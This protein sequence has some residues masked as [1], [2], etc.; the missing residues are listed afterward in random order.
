MLVWHGASIG[1]V[2]KACD[3]VGAE[4][5]SSS[6]ETDAVLYPDRMLVLHGAFIG[7]GGK[8]NGINPFRS[9]LNKLFISL[10]QSAMEVAFAAIAVD[11]WMTRFPPRQQ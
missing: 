3:Q 9:T 8:A 1:T 2:R 6:V 5:Q 11:A 4:S 7:T 10:H